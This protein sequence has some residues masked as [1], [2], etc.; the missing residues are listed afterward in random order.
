M[1]TY[2]MGGWSKTKSRT[3]VDVGRKWWWELKEA[4][5][6]RGMWG[7]IKTGQVQQCL[8]HLPSA[9]QNSRRT[10]SQHCYLGSISSAWGRVGVKTSRS[11]LPAVV[12][13]PW[14]G[15]VR[16]HKVGGVPGC[17]SLQ[18]GTHWWEFTFTNRHSPDPAAASPTS[19]CES[20]LVFGNVKRFEG[21]I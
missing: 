15:R 21:L 4:Y 10:L 3:Y 5:I 14:W 7:A 18:V 12:N 9:L 1:T 11:I 17:G 16:C 8:L 6:Q 20:G 2:V 13:S 19:Q